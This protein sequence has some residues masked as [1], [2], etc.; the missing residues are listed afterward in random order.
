MSVAGLITGAQWA[1]DVDGSVRL[2]IGR[3]LV[4]SLGLAGA[5]YGLF[6]SARLAAGLVPAWKGRGMPKWPRW[7]R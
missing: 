3:R 5:G 7:I 2:G 6:T 4:D 1:L